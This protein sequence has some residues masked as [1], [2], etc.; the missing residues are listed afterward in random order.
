MCNRC[1][2]ENGIKWIKKLY[3]PHLYTQIFQ[4]VVFIKMFQQKLCTQF[5]F[6]PT[7]AICPANLF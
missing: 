3:Y 4:V 7:Y 1:S 5:L 2:G 6:P